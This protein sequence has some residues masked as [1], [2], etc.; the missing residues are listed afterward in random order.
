MITPEDRRTMI[1]LI[2]AVWDKVEK[3]NLTNIDKT[4]ISQQLNMVVD[5]AEKVVKS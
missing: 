3:S 5:I 4:T 2:N 1:N